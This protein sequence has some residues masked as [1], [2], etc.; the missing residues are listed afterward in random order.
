MKLL[1]AEQYN[2]TTPLRQFILKRGNTAVSSTYTGPAGEITYDTGLNA[3][4]VHDGITPGGNLMPSSTGYTSL[5][6]NVT[7]L[8]S[9]VSTLFANAAAQAISINTINANVGAFQIFS[10]ANAISQQT[11]INLLNANV[12]AA[13]ALIP[14]LMA[15]S[16]NVL[17]SANVT[18][19][20]GSSTHQW[21]DLWVSNNTIYIGNTPIRVDGGTLLVNNAP[22]GSTYGNANVA[23]Y[24]SRGNVTVGNI[25]IQ[26]EYDQQWRFSNGALIWPAGDGTPTGP[27]IE[28]SS[29]MTVYPENDGEFRIQTYSTT[30]VG[31][32]QWKFTSEGNL[33]V[34]DDA[35]I[36]SDLDLRLYAEAGNI[37]LGNQNGTWMFGNDGKLTAPGE[38]YGQFFTLRGGNGPGAEI[39]SLG[40]GGNLVTVHSYEG[41]RVETGTPESGP[42]WQFDT[43]GNL[44]LPNNGYL[45]LSGGAIWQTPDQDLTIRVR[46]ADND[47]FELRLEV[48]DGADNVYSRF[49]QRRDDIQLGLGLTGSAKYYRFRDTGE[50]E[51]PG[52]ILGE[53]GTSTS[54]QIRGA[55]SSSFVTLKTVDN[56]DTLRSNV[57]V[58]VDNVVISTGTAT[59]NWI[60]DN[61]GNLT[62]PETGYLRVGSGIVAGFAS[63]PAPVISGFSS[64][65]AEN[66]TF[67]GNGVNI[68]SNVATKATGS[69]TV[70]TGT[71]NYSFTV[72]QNGT[73][74]LW[75]LGNIPNGIVKWNAT[76]TISNNNVPVVGAQYA[77][78]YNGAGTPIDFTSIPNQFTGTANTIVRSAGGGVSSTNTFTFGINNTSGNTQTV[79]YGWVKIS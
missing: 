64:V 18:Y 26:D 22:V 48:D 30:A 75:V 56:T 51:I 47:D 43:E 65:S 38:V 34:P 5:I 76:A 66:F 31:S 74:M 15:I 61:T 17:P 49:R 57:T 2:M 8:Q 60:F 13:N 24:L 68:L 28:G 36:H 40:Y 19:S 3:V 27:Y 11:Q 20:L 10:N 41:F 39:G 79:N 29:L 32:R 21:R 44:T 9:N 4:R 62:V 7:V 55:T 50:L 67:Q 77:W 12:S 42:Q 37:A 35:T 16:S 25:T 23:T 73:Y 33:I 46:D 14:N 1:T 63:S 6:S 58:G 72:D 71:D 45:N 78:V 53:Y 54:L 69:W 52:D 70:T 59:K